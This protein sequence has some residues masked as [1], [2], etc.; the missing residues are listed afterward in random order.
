MFFVLSCLMLLRVHWSP[1][2]T[3]PFLS[4]STSSSTLFGSG[5]SS[6]STGTPDISACC[7]DTVTCLW[8]ASG[9]FPVVVVYREHDL[10][11]GGLFSA[12]NSKVSAFMVSLVVSRLVSWSFLVCDGHVHA[13]T[14]LTCQWTQLSCRW[15]HLSCRRTQL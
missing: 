2:V 10:R 9:Y 14:Q 1:G 8:F 15:T 7:A 6:R 4:C 3:R 5:C 12:K 13:L 11:C